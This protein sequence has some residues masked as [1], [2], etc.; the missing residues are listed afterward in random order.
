MI[1]KKT[2]WGVSG[3]AILLMAIKFVTIALGLAI[4][5]LLSEYLTVYDY[6]TYSQI[7]LIVSTVSAFTIL[8]MADGINYFNSVER[9]EKKRESC[10]STIF[11]LQCIAGAAAGCFVMLLCGPLCRY[12]DNPGL[13]RLIIFA[14]ALPLLQNLLSMLQVLIVS[15]GRA[16]LLAFR[17][18]AVSLIRLGIVTF[19]VHVVQETAIIL[20]ATVLLDVIQIFLFWTMLKKSGYAIDLRKTDFSLSKNIFYYCA[21]M[22]VFMMINILNRDIDKYFVSLMTDIETSAIYLNASK[23]LPFDI[24]VTSFCTVL[25]PEITR[26]IAA[27]ENAKAVSVYK[28]FLEIAYVSTGTLCCAA[29][30]ASP[31][32]MKLLYSN[33]YLSGLSV[34]CIYIL[35]DLFRFTNITLVLSAAGKTKKLMYLG[36]GSLLAN[37]VLNAVLFKLFDIN[38][39]A[40]STL[41]VTAV[42]GIMMMSMSAKELGTTIGGFFDKKYLGIFVLE[43][44]A[45]TAVFYAVQSWLEIKDVHYF[46]ILMTICGAYGLL[47]LALHGKRMFRSLKKVNETTKK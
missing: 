44:L 3:D 32:L 23:A 26:L 31:Q 45:A 21:P 6:G 25:L 18:L 17:N 11:S 12:F 19:V 37:V 5:R 43:S 40:L 2:R 35:V 8:G 42:T 27:R 9:D 7:L 41:A 28:T 47:M 33:K 16:R 4:T 24:I 30:A 46:V 1:N 34:F 14:A 10:V 29:M 15:I 39:P 13:K 36:A 22:A 38:G 20:S